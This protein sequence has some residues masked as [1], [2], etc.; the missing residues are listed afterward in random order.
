M[1]VSQL[2]L[3]RLPEERR[4]ETYQYIPSEGQ[5]PM[6]GCCMS[7]LLEWTSRWDF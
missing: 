5:D 2:H 6:S 1:L 3:L 4:E 7:I